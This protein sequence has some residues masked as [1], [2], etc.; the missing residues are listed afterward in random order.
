MDEK[1]TLWVE[2]DLHQIIRENDRILV[3][4][5]APDGIS[6]GQL[7]AAALQMLSG[8]KHEVFGTEHFVL[9]DVPKTVARVVNVYPDQEGKPATDQPLLPNEADEVVPRIHV[10]TDTGA[11]GTS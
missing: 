5:I 3:K 10:P 9:A 6:R 4:I 8:M 2:F 11:G 7:K 1:L